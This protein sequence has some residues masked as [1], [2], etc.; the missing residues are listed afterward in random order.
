MITFLHTCEKRKYCSCWCRQIKTW[1]N[2]GFEHN[3]D[4]LID[5]PWGF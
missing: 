3:F 5:G 1:Q 2:V 4:T